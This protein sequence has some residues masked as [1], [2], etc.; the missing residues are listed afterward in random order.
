MVFM[1]SGSLFVEYS[2]S[3]VDG[4]DPEIKSFHYFPYNENSTRALK[5][6]LTQMLLAF[7]SRY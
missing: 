3:W 2:M 1:K 7:N 6:Y 4:Y 5:H